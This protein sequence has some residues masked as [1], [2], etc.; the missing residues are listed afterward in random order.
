MGTLIWLQNILTVAVGLGFVIFFHELGH[1]LLAKWNGVK[2][3]KF[4]IGFGPP[5]IR[6]RGEETEYALSAFPLGG[7][8]KMLGE[9]PEE[10]SE[11]E[12]DPRAYN[13]K[14]VGA[15]MA[16]ISAGVI[17]NLILG[18]ACFTIAYAWGGLKEVSGEIGSVAAGQPAY[19]AGIRAGDKIV[20]ID[21]HPDASFEDLMRTVVLS[22]S[23]QVVHLDLERP[24]RKDRISV[25]VEPRREA[26]NDRPT[27][28]I[29]FAEDLNLAPKSP[30]LAPP[31][32]D[33]AVPMPDGGFRGGDRIVAVGP[34][35]EEARP[36]ASVRE[37]NRLMAEFRDKPLTFVVER[38]ASDDAST[39][40]GGKA[41]GP[42]K[43]RV[44][45]PPNRFLDLGARMTMGPIAAIQGGSEAARA[46]FR[47][48]DRILNVDGSDD[49]DPIRLPTIVSEAAGRPLTFEVQ[50]PGKSGKPDEVVTLTATPDASPT[51]TEN[52]LAAE[53]LE[54]PGLG[55]AFEVRPEVARVIEGSPAA[56]AGL[57]PGDVLRSMTLTYPEEVKGKKK[58]RSLTF[59]FG[60][61]AKGE[62]EPDVEQVGWPSAFAM[63]QAG[64]GNPSIVAPEPEVKFTLVGSKTPISIRPEPDPTWFHPQRGLQFDILQ[65]SAPPLGLVEATRRGGGEAVEKMAEVYYMLRGLG[66]GRVSGKNIGGPIRIAQI[67]YAFASSG[68][69]PFIYFLGVLS[70]NLTVLNFL[71]IPPLDGGQMMFLIGE[72]IRGRPLP[73]SALAGLTWA[74]LF[75]VLGLMAFFIF[76]DVKLSLF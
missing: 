6:W 74:G 59:L 44:T 43:A 3:E 16:I 2:V 68:L 5:L 64:P 70:V 62:P 52:V 55:L 54:V 53:P 12:N 48:G 65:K 76:Q 45:L 39:V 57:K 36:V 22:G 17:M 67:A 34:A 14:S 42:A 11:T 10:V 29:G 13:N 26:D 21:G 32:L 30:Y 20:A 63:I 46:G 51:W 7:F 33:G 37:L 49:F 73:E 18:L 56:K 60:V 35:D 66:Q 61:P 75:L 40:A 27:I 1:F 9:N 71:P 24:G 25:D 19:A 58:P 31:G 38:S 72:K 23:G 47:T 69:A 8:V 50:R 28:G 41:G 4:S 15:R